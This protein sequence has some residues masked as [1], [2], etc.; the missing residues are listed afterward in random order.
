MYMVNARAINKEIT[1]KIVKRIIKKL[2]CYIRKYSL[3]VKESSKRTIEE[4][5][6]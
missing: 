5:K 6:R 1:K 2:R 3:N 4:Q